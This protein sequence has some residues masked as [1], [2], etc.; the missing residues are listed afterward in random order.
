MKNFAINETPCPYCGDKLLGSINWY[1]QRPP[2]PGDASICLTCSNYS[3]FTPS[4]E[5]RKTQHW[6]LQILLCDNRHK[7]LLSTVESLREYL[8]QRRGSWDYFR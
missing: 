2:K 3:I 5:L 6:E 7:E 8:R 1:N 4:M